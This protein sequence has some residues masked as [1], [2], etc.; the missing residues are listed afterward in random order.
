MIE[1]FE[2]KVLGPFIKKKFF[3]QTTEAFRK[4]YCWKEKSNNYLLKNQENLK[5]IFHTYT[6]KVKKGD[7]T[8]YF[9]LQSALRM[10]QDAKINLNK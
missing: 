8:N 10:L 9:T 3:D 5:R 6:M 2:S 7:A 4:E 1:F